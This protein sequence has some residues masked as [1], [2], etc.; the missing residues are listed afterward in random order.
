MSAAPA[1]IPIFVLLAIGL[2]LIVTGAVLA[3]KGFWPKRRGQQPHCGECDYL[4]IGIQSERCPECGTVITA[5]NTLRGERQRRMGLGFGGAGLVLLGLGLLIV[6]VAGDI[7]NIPWY[8]FKPTFMVM[9]DLKGTPAA[10]ADAVQELNRREKAG[11]LS[12][13]YEQQLIEMALAQQA[14]TGTGPLTQGLIEFLAE[15]C[16]AGHLT[17]AQ[18]TRF[19]QQSLVL[20]VHVRPI[21]VLGDWV[22][23]RINDA[24][25]IVGPGYCVTY[26]CRET[27]IDGQKV[28]SSGGGGSMNG[29]GSGGSFGNTVPSKEVG[30]HHLAVTVH[31]EV[32]QGN[33]QSGTVLYTE[34][35]TLAADFQVVAQPPPG[36]F[37]LINDPKLGDL[38][39][40]SIVPVGFQISA[41]QPGQLNCKLKITGLPGNIAFDVI[42]RLSGREFNVGDITCNKGTTTEYQL[43]L[44]MPAELVGASTQ[45]AAFDL[46]LRSDEKVG[47]ATIDLHDIWNGELIYPNVPVVHSP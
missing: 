43:G 32:K 22:P 23:F 21:V 35:R 11:G 37:S 14:T 29:L 31:V 45:P 34:D 8:H 40:A 44:T 39:R 25:R 41:R 33:Y 7:G 19:G 27:D 26:E 36:Y 42:A 15:Q 5:Q 18:K 2:V 16:A 9:G 17:D 47:R 38:I 10:A 30:T 3:R 6:P 4:L 24:S 13:K 46:I 20:N 1:S 12:A 28:L